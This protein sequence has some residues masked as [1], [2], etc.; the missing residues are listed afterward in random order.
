M[1]KDKNIKRRDFFKTAGVGALALGT[2]PAVKVIGQVGND[3]VLTSDDQYG[4][5]YVRRHAIG[6]PPYKVDES[7]YKRFDPH[8]TTFSRMMYDPEMQE[9]LANTPGPDW[10][11][12][13]FKQENA[14]FENGAWMIANYNGTDAAMHSKHKGMLSLDLPRPMSLADHD[15]QQK[16]FDRS[17]MTDKDISTMIKKAAMFYGSSLVGIAKLDKKWIYSHSAGF[18]PDDSGKIEFFKP[19]KVELP[20]GSVTM[21]QAKEKVFAELNKKEPA[22]FKSFLIEVMSTLDPSVMG[23]EMPGDPVKMLGMMPPKQ[24]KSM[25]PK[26]FETIPK[27]V[28]EAYAN[29]LELD[30]TIVQLD[31]SA[32]GKPHYDENGDLQ[33]PESM[34]R[35][36]VMAFEMDYDTV[37][38]YPTLNGGAAAMHGYSRMAVTASALATM[39]RELGYNAI[40][41]GNNTGLSV[42]MAIDA[43]LGELGRQGVLIT[44][45]YG[46][47]VRLAKVITDLPLAVDRPISFGVKEFCDICMK[48]A[49]ECPSQAIMH[50]DQVDHS[51]NFSN[52]PG[53]MKW[54]INPVKCQ[55]GWKMSGSDCGICI[56]TCP[57]NKIDGWL[58]EITRVLIGAKSGNLDKLMLKMDDASGYGESTDPK[59][60]WKGERF[61]HTSSYE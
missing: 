51:D 40:A 24:V 50:G 26:I 33:I 6:D 22:E 31:P 44:P 5:F 2:L 4:G 57:F 37:M 28:L 9:A 30:M 48:C 3:E 34:N 16:P 58:H 59:G 15:Y 20:E 53:V 17:Q 29:A 1:S 55:T 61:I 38:Q 60:Y 39:I 7:V 47:R 13:G 36:V 49:K 25:A 43:G 12:P 54:P 56:K 52:N 35:V 18:S 8:N 23:D 19:H 21:K 10:G 32:F 42:P 46:P 45:K 11:T 27:E 14:A 41:C